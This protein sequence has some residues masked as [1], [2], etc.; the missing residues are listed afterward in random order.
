MSFKGWYFAVAFIMGMSFCHPAF[1]HHDGN[2]SLEE[3]NSNPLLAAQL[4]NEFPSYSNSSYQQPIQLSP[5]KNFQSLKVPKKINVSEKMIVINPRNHTWSAYSASG[6]LIRSGIATAGS[7]WCPDIG[8]SCRTKTGVFRIQ[9]LG[10]SDCKSTRYPVGH[11]GAPMPFCMFFNGNQGLHGSYEV[12][13]GNISHGCVRITVEAARWIR[14]NFAT[15]G[16]KVVVK[17]Y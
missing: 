10:G 8:R 2:Y 9:S 1:S 17:P 15:I 3:V 11:P 16:T 7:G 6:Q 12:V 4:N 5:R 13:R 14:Y